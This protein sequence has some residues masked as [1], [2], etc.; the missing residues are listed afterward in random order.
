MDSL[1]VE[2]TKKGC[3][4]SNHGTIGEMVEE[5]WYNGIMV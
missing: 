4:R 5:E 3:S 2:G 1:I